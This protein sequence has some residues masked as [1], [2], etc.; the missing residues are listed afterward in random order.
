MT[1]K[2]R[3]LLKMRNPALPAHAQAANDQ[4]SAD[5]QALR[6]A[7]DRIGASA[8]DIA[9]WCRVHR[10]TV[11]R[12]LSGKTTIS[13]QALVRSRRLYPVFS[14]CLLETLGREAA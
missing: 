10:T 14:Q 1:E 4:C 6:M 3:P 2:L 5:V 8:A 13:L 7:K 9:S 12:W 11:E